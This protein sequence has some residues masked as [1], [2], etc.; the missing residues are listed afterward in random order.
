MNFQLIIVYVIL[1]I[2]I[3]YGI[4]LFVKFLRKKDDPC[5]GCSGCDIKNEIMKNYN[6]NKDKK[7]MKT[8]NKMSSFSINNSDEIFPIVDETGKII[9][10]ATRK[11]CHSNSTMLHP[12]V[13]IH[14]FNSAGELYLQKRALTKDIQPGKWDTAVGG[15]VDYGETIEAAVLRE[16]QEELGLSDIS[17]KFL[18]RYKWQSE[19]ESELIYV[20]GLIHDKNISPNPDELSEGQFWKLSEIKENIGKGIFTPNFEHDFNL[21]QINYIKNLKWKTFLES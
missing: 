7:F 3:S 19:I 10:K 13:H 21:L 5:V 1:V 8:M 11:E 18:Y 16:C 14:I 15:H 6:D 2:V 20:Y 9:G 4:Y 12:V 17:P